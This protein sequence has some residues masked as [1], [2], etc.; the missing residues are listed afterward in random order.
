MEAAGIQHAELVNQR[1]RL[2]QE[3]YEQEDKQVLT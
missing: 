1:Q 2:L 3:D